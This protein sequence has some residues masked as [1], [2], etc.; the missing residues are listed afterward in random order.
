MPSV[1]MFSPRDVTYEIYKQVEAKIGVANDPPDGLIVHTASEVDGQLRIVDIWESEEHAQ[2][3]GQ[4][5]LGPAIAEIAGDEMAGPPDPDQ[6]VIY[7]IK[8]M[9][10]P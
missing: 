3:F 6:V 7:E 4:E 8:S 5:R 10:R 2:R 9:V 1:R